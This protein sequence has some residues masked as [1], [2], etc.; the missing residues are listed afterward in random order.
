VFFF[1]VLLTE[2]TSVEKDVAVASGQQVVAGDYTFRFDGVQRATGPNYLSDRGSV[3]VFRG[4]R[5]IAVLHPEKRQYAAG[6]QIMTET[7]I[8]PA[9]NRDLY[10]ALGE[11]IDTRGGWALRVY[12]KPWVRCIWLGALLMALG[13]F[14]T[15]LDRR[16]RRNAEVA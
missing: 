5:Q 9:L 7:A 12:V 4:D 11:P 8:D 2:A 14:T 6:G 16:F 13:G 1:A 10:V 3:S 15:A